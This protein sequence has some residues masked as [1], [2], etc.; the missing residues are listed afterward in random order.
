MS[1]LNK[2][3][4]TL[5]EFLF[6]PFE[7]PKDD[8]P[9]SINTSIRELERKRGIDADTQ[10]KGA[11]QP[12]ADMAKDAV[13]M[14]KP[15]RSWWYVKR[16]I[17][18][19]IFGI[20]NFF[21]GVGY[22]LA[23]LALFIGAPFYY[24]PEKNRTSYPEKNRAGYLVWASCCIRDTYVNALSYFIDGILSMLRGATQLATT[25]LTWFIKAP[26]RGIIALVDKLRGKPH[27]AEQN[28][29]IK[30]FTQYAVRTFS[31]GTYWAT[32]DW[33]EKIHTKYLK[34]T[35]PKERD[36]ERDQDTR[37]KEKEHEA[38]NKFLESRVIK[39]TNEEYKKEVTINKASLYEY[40]NL[41]APGEIQK[42]QKHSQHNEKTE[43]ISFFIYK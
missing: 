29:G 24:I 14:F 6:L 34:A 31:C 43:A 9:R 27:L 37:I 3:Y 40:V 35:N 23:S 21:K 7:L 11:L 1:K 25:P 5:S 2:S 8:E 32:Y 12:L 36:Q 39:D 38:Y 20:G 16:D 13:D 19:P 30:E 18:Q 4:L 17:L 26:L 10:L 41:F 28:D 42:N 15:Y 22:V 33:V